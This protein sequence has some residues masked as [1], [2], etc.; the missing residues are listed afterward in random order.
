MV[1]QLYRLSGESLEL[2]MQSLELFERW[3]AILRAES[4]SSKEQEQ[5]QLYLLTGAREASFDVDF[6][7]RGSE[8]KLDQLR[9]GN[10]N[11]LH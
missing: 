9:S 7:R 5:N 6:V 2:G 4:K 3:V 1:H 8:D 10:P 11:Q